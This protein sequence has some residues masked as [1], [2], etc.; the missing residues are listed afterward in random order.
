M[1]AISHQPSAFSH[2]EDI[3]RGL[4]GEDRRTKADKLKADR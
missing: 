1:A 2:H 3:G 4:I